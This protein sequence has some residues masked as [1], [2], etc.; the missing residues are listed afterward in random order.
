MPVIGGEIIAYSQ[1]L[2]GGESRIFDWEIRLMF[3][4]PDL[5]YK[6]ASV[7][8]VEG[9]VLK[10]IQSLEKT[11]QIMDVL[12]NTSLPSSYSSVIASAL[13]W[14]EIEVKAENGKVWADIWLPNGRYKFSRSLSALQIKDCIEILKEVSERGEKMVGTL[15]SLISLSEK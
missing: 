7:G 5:R 11:Y 10:F 6:P 13:P 9:Q 14:P 8:L 12:K 15:K 3:T 4:G 2:R 1:N